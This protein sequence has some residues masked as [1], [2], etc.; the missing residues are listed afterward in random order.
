MPDNDRDADIR[1]ER[2]KL[3]SDFV[4][5]S[6]GVRFHGRAFS[7]QSAV[8][9]PDVG[10]A[11]RFGFTVTKKVGGAVERNR[12]RR[13]LRE[14]VRL[15]PDNPAQAGRDYVIFAK[16]DALRVSF[17]EMTEELRRA[18]FGVH[19]AAR[20]RTKRTNARDKDSNAFPKGPPRR[21]GDEDQAIRS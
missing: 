18:V 14:V 10:R 7:V 1:R 19:A 20:A 8:N 3:R 17:D 13:R 21:A 6:K 16:R 2:L 4:A 12:I 11:P 15:M 5:A 9:S